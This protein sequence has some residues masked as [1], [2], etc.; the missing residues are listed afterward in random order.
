MTDPRI[1]KLQQWFDAQFSSELSAGQARACLE[2]LDSALPPAQEASTLDAEEPD[3]SPENVARCVALLTSKGVPRVTDDDAR[4]AITDAH[5]TFGALEKAGLTDG[6][7]QT[8]TPPVEPS[9]V[10]ERMAKALFD[11]DDNRGDEW[12]EASE[13]MRDGYYQLARAALSAFHP[14]SALEM[15]REI[16][17]VAGTVECG[18]CSKR[19]KAIEEKARALVRILSGEAK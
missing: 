13:T 9:E 8:T 18:R 12:A 2:L 16:Q 6:A 10:V 19:N 1:A 11:A 14:P 15:A 4:K 17:A 3:L 5:R 7:R